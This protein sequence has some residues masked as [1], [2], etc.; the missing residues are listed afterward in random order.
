MTIDEIETPALLIDLDT[1]EKNIE[2]MASYYRTKKGAALRPHQKG[3]R[4][5]Q[6]A[7]K[8]IAAG[9]VGVSMTSPGL[10]EVYV[11]SGIED[12]LITRQVYGKTK[13]ARL[14]GLG[15]H[16]NVTQSVDSMENARQI[17]EISTDL[18]TKA[19]VA[20]EIYVDPV[21]C[22]VPIPKMKEFVSEVSKMPGI[23]FRG[24]WWHEGLLTGDVA[25]RRKDHFA[26][27]DRVADMKDD[28]DR[29]G[30]EIEM[31]SGGETNTWNITPEYPRLHDV[32]VQAGNYVFTDWVDHE[33]DGLGVFEPALTV[34]TRCI[35]RPEPAVAVFDAGL[36][37]IANEASTNYSRI[38]GPKFKTLRGIDRVNLREEMT[39][40]DCKNASEEIRNGQLFELIP[41]H[42]DTTAKLHDRYYGIRNGK[43]EVIWQNS[44]RG[45]L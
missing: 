12:I 30:L 8:Q 10:A 2:T 17:S 24:L 38:V 21:G 43:V 29:A 15:K 5:P 39:Y 42:A 1:M 45:M 3:H 14:C 37:S 23:H 16:G 36:N 44:G 7:R 27:M 33:E 4:L 19:N 22:G 28:L 20:V 6:I 25:Q 41:P 34:L 32:G 35:S 40:I 11:N 26:F 13:I 18:G 31:L 9:A